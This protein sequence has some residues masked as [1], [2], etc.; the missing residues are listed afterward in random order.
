MRPEPRRAPR[1]P[2]DASEPRSTSGRGPRRRPSRSAAARS[3]AGS[4]SPSGPGEFVALMG[5]NGSGKSTLV[6]AITGLLPLTRRRRLASSARRTTTSATGSGSA[7]CR[8][9]RPRPAACPRRSGRSSPRDASAGGAA[10]CAALPRADR[11]AIDARD[12]RRRAVR[13]HRAY[14]VS[15]LSRRAAAARPDRPRTGRRA[16]P[17]GARRAHRRRRPAATSAPSPTRSPRFK[18]GG[19][20]I[21]LVAH[22][23][24]PMAPLI[25][26]AVV[27]RDGRIAYDGPAL[28][29]EDA[30]GAPPPA[31]RDARPR[32]ARG[33]AARRA[34]G[35]TM[36]D[37]VDLFSLPFMQRALAR[38]PA[39]RPGR[40]GDRHLPRAAP[41]R[42][43]G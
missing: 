30:H 9:A 3:C 11:R 29:E 23:L 5:A 7:S 37:F 2:T 12:R 15:Q 31:G 13:P 6:R 32:P 40:A 39:D 25:D 22:E 8:S 33:I 43:A 42:P 26:R 34:G 4:T 36:S 35:R 17:A 18:A 14:G 19:A 24:G 41:P 20:T 28:D 27:M 1:R 16:R 21:V 10:C 38:R